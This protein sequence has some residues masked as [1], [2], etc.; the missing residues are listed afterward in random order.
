MRDDDQTVTERTR[1]VPEQVFE[2]FIEAL[3]EAGVPKELVG[4]LRKTLI[5][6]RI[7]TESA[8]KAAIF[9]EET[10]P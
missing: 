7:F 9:G 2:Q 5:E 4:R 8:M 3:Q 1:T 6:D 10:R